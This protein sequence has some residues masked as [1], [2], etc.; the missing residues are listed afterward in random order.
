M[1]NN[2]FEAKIK[3]RMVKF[4]SVDG[5]SPLE[6]STI[7]GQVEDKINKIEEKLGIVDS[8]KL[9]ILAAFDF[10]VELYNLRQKSETN[11]EA[12]SKKLEDMVARLENTLE[13][14]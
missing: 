2:E 1:S 5:M 14:K 11:R 13:E 3:N 7:V 12:D 6:M 9:A 8:S 4:P 10:A